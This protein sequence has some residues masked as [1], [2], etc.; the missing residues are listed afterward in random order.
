MS[1]DDLIEA[2]TA[3]RFDLTAESPNALWLADITGGI[4]AAEV[5]LYLCAVKV[6]WSKA[7]SCG[8][9]GM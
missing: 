7:A 3:G 5:K 2:K 4:Q 1:A 9:R 8:L 6:V